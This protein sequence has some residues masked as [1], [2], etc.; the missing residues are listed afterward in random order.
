MSAD[1]RSAPAEQPRSRYVLAGTGNRGTTMWGGE[2]LAGWNDQ[3]ELVGICDLND[4]RAERARSMIRTNAPIWQDF[5]A[6]LSETRPDLVIVCTPDDTHDDLIVAAL[7]AGSD[8]ITEK[9]MTTSPEKIARIRAAEKRTGRRVDVSFNYRFSP[10][11]YRIR[12]LIASGA[13]GTVTSVD[14]HWYLDTDHGA[15]YFRRWHAF[16]EHSG[17]L[18]VHKATHHFDLL[19]WYL[20]ADPVDVM[21]F[22]ELRNYGHNGPFRSTRC[23]GCPH[24]SECNYYF[25]MEADDFL[26]PLYGDPAEID[27]YFRDACVYREEI[28]IPDTMSSTIRY[29]NGAIVSYSLNTYMPIEGHHIAFNGTHGRIELRQYERQPWEIDAVDRIL[30]TR[31]FGGGH[32][33]IEVPHEPGG[34]YGGDNRMRDTIFRR[35]EDPLGQRAGS[36]AGAMSVLTGIAALKSA[37]EGRLV[38]IEEICPPDL[39]LGER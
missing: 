32:E 17:S 33:V 11:S 23:H 21:A 36:R 7:E 6:C 1:D 30:L 39:D 22:G 9:P 14:F 37:D 4:M 34:H 26:W 28:D 12:E 5:D 2:L 35:G 15:D 16:R 20:D 18:F 3:V 8:V 27:G 25:D 19:N 13:I 38:T 10:T 29:S 24:A 31:N